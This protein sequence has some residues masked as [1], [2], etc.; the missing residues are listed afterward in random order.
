MSDNWVNMSGT[1][2]AQTA[3][4]SQLYS[5]TNTIKDNAGNKFVISSGVASY[6]PMIG[7]DENPFR[8]PVSYK[9]KQFLGLD[10]F[11]YIEQP[12]CESFF[13]AA[14]VGYS[15]VSVKNI[16]TGDAETANRTG[17]TISEFYTAK[18]YPVK[19]DWLPLERRKPMSSNILKLVSAVVVDHIGLSQGYVVELNDMHGKEKLLLSII[20]RGRRSH[21]WRTI[22]RRL[23]K[24]PKRKS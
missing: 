21:P 23:M 24:P 13:P 10:N 9:Q 7:N 3:T 17:E 22:I 12:F 11:Y 15:K 5:Y 14:T 18:E 19:V 6:E 16:G 4:Y 8:Q 1:P 2:G 20:D